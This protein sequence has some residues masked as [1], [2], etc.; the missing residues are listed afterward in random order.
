M[1]AA[2]PPVVVRPPTGAPAPLVF[3]SPHSGSTYPDGFETLLPLKR[4]RRAEDAFV[5][6]LFGAA[7]A[8]GATLV[9][10]T[11]PRLFVDPN[12][13][14]DDFEPSE[15][16]GEFSMPLNPSKKA[17]AGKGIVWTR[18]HGLAQLYAE[19]LTAAEVERRIDGY[20]R[21]YH[22][23]VRTALDE[24]HAAFGRVF[25]VNC[26]SMRAR[27]NP[28]DEDGEADRP[29]FVISDRDGTTSAAEFTNLVSGHL[30]GR[31]FDVRVNDPYKG[32]ELVRAYSDPAAGRHSVQIEINRKLYMEEAAVAKIAAFDTFRDEMT[33]LIAA[34]AAYV[35]DAEA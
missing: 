25:H 2:P 30:A 5:D 3:D 28:T 10:A 16:S 24:T 6:E 33:G 18:L 15:V 22:A 17:A 29:D 34:I 1:T 31:G 19:P 9:A 7:P 26:H 11:F 12:R 27:G 35:A 20:W 14:P 23:A 4:M 32:A 8:H 21:P 13:A